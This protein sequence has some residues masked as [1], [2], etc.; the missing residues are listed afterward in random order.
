MILNKKNINY[1]IVYLIEIYKFGFGNFYIQ[2]HSN[3]S[4]INFENMRASNI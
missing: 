4:K 2:V 3:N 1:K